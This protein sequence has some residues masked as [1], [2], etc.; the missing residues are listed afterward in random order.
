MN[1]FFR[2]TYVTLAYTF[3]EHFSFGIL[4]IDSVFSQNS[5]IS[6]WVWFSIF[7]D[8]GSN[9][10]SQNERKNVRRKYRLKWHKLIEKKYSKF[11]SCLLNEKN[12]SLFKD[13]SIG[14]VINVQSFANQTKKWLFTLLLMSF[15]Y[16]KQ[17]TVLTFHFFFGCLLSPEKL[18]N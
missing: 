11:N 5:I 3:F 17:F 1:I 2:L 16:H 9:I 4:A 18:K 14:V 12:I 13:M 6:S 15:K 10:M 8:N 7:G